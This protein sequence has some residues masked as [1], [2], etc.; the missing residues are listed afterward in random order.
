M[1]Y[2]LAGDG[3]RL[4]EKEAPAAVLLGT[5]GFEGLTE[6]TSNRVYGYGPQGGLAS[7]TEVGRGPSRR[8]G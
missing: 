4:A 6:P 2:Q 8:E 1:V 3:T 5:G 7:V